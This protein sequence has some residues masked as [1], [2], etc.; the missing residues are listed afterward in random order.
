MNGLNTHFHYVKQTNQYQIINN[1]F[2][3]CIFDQRVELFHCVL[4]YNIHHYVNTGRVQNMSVRRKIQ[5]HDR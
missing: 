5:G 3:L 2:M 4:N 1:R